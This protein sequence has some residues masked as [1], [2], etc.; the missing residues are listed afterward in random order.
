MLQA[1][2]PRAAH[3][4]LLALS[5]TLAI[6][7][8]CPSLATASSKPRST[9]TSASKL[10]SS[11]K[12]S[13]SKKSAKCAAN[14]GRG[15]SRKVSKSCPAKKPKP[16][17]PAPSMHR[18]TSGPESHIS[19][20]TP[21]TS[22]PPDVA[23]GIQAPASDAG[24]PQSN[25]S[26]TQAVETP[27]ST[28]TTLA[29][30][31]NP[32]TVGQAVT[33]TAKLSSSAA[34]GTVEFQ[35]GGVAIPR[36][37]AQA[38]GSGSANCT[39]ETYP[40]SGPH[41]I[42]A[43]YSGDSHFLA[44][45][46]SS[47]TQA[48]NKAATTTAVSSATNPSN[49][50]QAVTYV[51]TLSTANAT[52]SI[53]F[54]DNGTTITGCGTQTVN[55]AIA[56]C[57]VPGYTTANTHGITATYSG[58]NNYTASVSATLTQ[59]INQA[60]TTTGI[61]SATNPSTVGEAV[62]YTATVNPAAATDTVEFKDGGASIAGC[63]A[64]TITSGAATCTTTYTEAGPHSITAT[65]SGDSNYLSSVSTTMTQTVNKAITAVVVSSGTNPA[66]VGQAI[67]YTATVNPATATG[68]IEFIDE[69]TLI[70]GCGA[71][72]IGSGAAT[73]T[74]TYT[75]AGPHSITATYSGDSNDL[76]SASSVWSQ[77]VTLTSVISTTS[78]SSATNPANIGQAV[79]YTATVS[80]AAGTGT[81][82]FKDA[83]TAITGCS[84][85][86][87]SLGIATCT[88][89]SY[90]G[91]GT[92]PITAVY[93]GDV[94]DTGSTSTALTQAINKNVAAILLSSGANP[95]KVGQSATYTAS[96][97]PT[98][99][100]GTVEFQ[101]E[102]IPISGCTTQ[103]INLGSA[104]C[105]VA[106]YASAGSHTITG[107]YS[108]D[109]NDSASI[110]TFLIQTISKAATTIALASSTNPSRSGQALTYTATVTPTTGTGTV[111][112]KD[113]GATITGC[114]RQ[115]LSLG[116]A[117][118]PIASYMGAG[119]HTITAVY[120]GDTADTGSASAIL[121]ETVSKATTATV[122]SSGTNPSAIGQAVTYTA[123]LN[124]AAAT[125]TVEFRDGGTT[126]TGCTTQAVSSGGATCTVVGYTGA[127][128]RTITAL[129]SGDVNY[130][131][132]T[133]TALTQN[134]SKTATTI[135]VSSGINPATAGQ[136]VTYTAQLN[137]TGAT[138]IVEFKDGSTAIT[139]CTTQTVS[140]SS[141]TCTVPEYA[142]AGSHEITAAYLGDNNYL[143]SKSPTLTQSVS[144]TSGT[145]LKVATTTTSAS[146][147]SPSVVG[148]AVTYTATLNPTAASGTVVFQDG[149]ITIA[150]CSAQTVS[151][152][153]ATCATSYTNEGSHEI[154]A[155][156]TGSSNYI[157]SRS[158]ALT[159]KVNKAPTTTTLTSSVSPST[160]GQAVTYTATL[161]TTAVS[162]TVEF[163]D[164][165]TTIT[166][167]ATQ[168]ISSSYA[169]ATC[170]ATAYATA[171]T[172]TITAT[173]NGNN[174]YISST[175]P[176]LTQ[177]VSKAATTIKLT[178]STNPSV[179]GQAVTYTAT[180]NTTAASG[181]VEFKDG[182]TTITECTTQTV[183]S[184][185]A[186]C[187]VPAYIAAGTHTI[188]ATYSGDSNYVGSTSPSLIQTV[189][190][191]TT[192][193]TLTSSTSPSIV[194]QSVTY[195]AQ[196]NTTTAIGTV[197]FVDAGTTITGC[198]TQTVSSGRATCTTIYAAPGSHE[199]VA[200]Y[201]GSS[202]YIASRSTALTQT[203]NKVPTTT[204]LTSSTNPSV[205]GQ[206]VTYTATLNPTATSGTVVFQ[207]GGITIAGCSAQTVSLGNAT[208]TTS[209][210]SEGSHEIVAI[211]TG[212]SNYIASRSTTLTQTVN[213]APTTTTLT[214]STNPSII[215]Q[216]VT[217]TATL[218]TTAASGTV[219]FKDGS[220][221][222]TGCA[223]Q[224]ISSAQATCLVAAYM[225]AGVHT[226]TAAYSGAG[227][228]ASSTSPG[229]PQTVEKP[230][231]GNP[232][233]LRFFSSASFWNEQL[234]A[235]APLDPNSTTV[236]GA[237]DEEITAAEEAKEG[238]PTVNTTSWSI[239][240]YTVPANQPMVEVHLVNANSAALQSAWAAVPIPANA[241]PAVGTDEH[242]VVSQ[243]STN[244]LWEFW[245]L[246]KT[247]AGWQAKW[248][249][250]IEKVS[251]NSGAYGPEAWPGA[252]TSWGASA[253]SLSIAGGLITLEDLERSQINHAL[254]ISLPHVRAR[255][256]ASPAQRTDGVDSSTLSLPEGAHLRLDPNL[257]LAS[258]HLPKF[259]L[260]MAEAAQ[261]Y[262]I[263]VRDSA[264]NVAFYG[265]DPTPTG[266][267]PY[268]GTQGYFEGK[269]LTELL[270]LFPWTHLQLLKMELH[271]EP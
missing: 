240:I 239:P 253:S 49:V 30:S 170:L 181:T 45:T 60:S 61:S 135:S 4:R 151:L 137:T 26:S 66:T 16:S 47:L 42:T 88:V 1:H 122:V 188:T 212:S 149:G 226:I 252:T 146:S 154:V 51:A 192:K 64:R 25:G 19:L 46:S 153:T 101:D 114:A 200:I 105:N 202:N 22:V 190:K 52:G 230:S 222:I 90:A 38:V 13:S 27:P 2:R 267:N 117:T 32:S 111:E 77:T 217:Y 118:C 133:S 167:C 86:T 9:S 31:G 227:K 147:V 173:Y 255:V 266:T 233:P 81:V 63:G 160:I 24:G 15:K 100:T 264:S 96:I 37:S 162:G 40:S 172:H 189:N 89:A 241:K 18:G 82:Q 182:S 262:G 116:S 205:V 74:T 187:L 121:T 211:Y 29:S 229:M 265:Q 204:T 201:T 152:G 145:A 231:A 246:E 67:T 254:A 234:P 58:D 70:T 225:A 176:S 191:I 109:A 178:P 251:S 221:T 180:L 209:Y 56:T 219:E 20:T 260:M 127:G 258:L 128:S 271:S 238:R 76:A 144:A 79:T 28:T 164:G 245:G 94:N 165:S 44:S 158:T 34:T 185:H 206:A 213:K 69:G 12:K 174:K 235:D 132:S 10:Q 138:G 65:Y 247:T 218:N 183:S 208:C 263:I 73:C 223:T 216:V 177:T 68:T 236:I 33:Y 99:A 159:Q 48:V 136:A 261:R 131:G 243:P 143:T 169:H 166:G 207:D 102:G 249:G 193:T 175:S 123:K 140:S 139:G 83:G 125:G 257:N 148:Q 98:I 119:P 248:G 198:A 168:T 104:E 75:E 232:A 130:T 35:D 215:G 270:E 142:T 21:F 237:F 54:K 203:V 87:V 80:P 50:G 112:F 8:V 242:L 163:K 71:Q 220:T 85:Q 110:S 161:N 256:Y 103:T 5:L 196:L 195:A 197:E 157:A 126:I 113:A 3:A 156:Y 23:L 250:A 186:T 134:I 6:A 214:S 124:T 141:A 53:E 150:G 11:R 268:T 108:G 224:T 84:A 228:Y 41:T 93:S 92:H 259:T 244:R 155:I 36:C 129:Y 72:T 199:V 57:T 39:I 210:T 59:T 91:A 120:S 194:G 179:V 17:K 62:T 95:S 269:S 14:T 7:A 78:V 55:I 106:T 171:G 107:V 184:T 43:A 115:T 97:S